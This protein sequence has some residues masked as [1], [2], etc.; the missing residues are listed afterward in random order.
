MTCLAIDFTGTLLVSGSKD[1][2][3]MIWQVIQEYGNSINL[4]PSP[5]HILYGHT[6]SVTSVD[7]SIELDMIVSASLDGTVNI[8][9]IRKGHFVKSIAFRDDPLKKFAFNNLTVK[10]SNQ[11]HL[12]VY[13]SAHM[14]R[15]NSE[16]KNIPESQVI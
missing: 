3:V 10:L 5:M 9:T 11:R 15:N 16:E 7:I 6:A 1:C 8:H 13:T 2:T 14:Q 12:L 4:D